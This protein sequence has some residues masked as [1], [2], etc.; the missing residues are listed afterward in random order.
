MFMGRLFGVGIHQAPREAHLSIRAR[1]DST[2]VE[3]GS[4]CVEYLPAAGP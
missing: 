4:T 3:I 1:E 2:Y